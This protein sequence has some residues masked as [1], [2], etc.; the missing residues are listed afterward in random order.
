M[1]GAAPCGRHRRLSHPTELSTGTFRASS[2]H[3]SARVGEGGAP[4]IPDKA[5]RASAPGDPIVR[6]SHLQTDKPGGSRRSAVSDHAAASVGGLSF[7][8]TWTAVRWLI[9]WS[10]AR[11]DHAC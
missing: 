10:S 2:R 3:S 5:L 8:N 11:Q 4:A 1:S 7:A 9:L 6:R